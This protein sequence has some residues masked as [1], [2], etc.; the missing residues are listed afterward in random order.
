M[1]AGLEEITS[2]D[3]FIGDKRMN[4]IPPANRNIGMVFQSYALY[5]IFL[6]Q[7]ICRSV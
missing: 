7:R 6:L 1:I 2:G 4:D 5:P 3:L